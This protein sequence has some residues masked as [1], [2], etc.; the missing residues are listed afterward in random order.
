MVSNTSP[1]M[2]QLCFKVLVKLVLLLSQVQRVKPVV[3]CHSTRQV[4]LLA[5]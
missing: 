3:A 4:S 2:Q 1:G 5:T